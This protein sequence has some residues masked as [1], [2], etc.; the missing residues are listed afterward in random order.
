[1]RATALTTSDESIIL[2]AVPGMLEMPDEYVRVPAGQSRRDEYSFV[3]GSRFR[4]T[5]EF[6]LFNGHY[7]DCSESDQGM[8]VVNLAYLS[9]NPVRVRDQAWRWLIASIVLVGG[10]TLTAVYA[11]LMESIL[12]SVGAMIALYGYLN[13]LRSRII[14]RTRYGGIAVFEIAASVLRRREAERFVSLL[15]E[16][17]EGAAT[18]LPTGEKRLAAEMAE[19]R[20]MLT[21]GWLSKARYDLAKHRIFARYRKNA[22]R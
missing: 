4:R 21:E 3:Q 18:I 8:R 17:I 20:R 5:R 16:R 11:Q 19:H 10:A 13:S 1:M 22:G 12:L 14:F 7:L 2:Q 6:V 15:C 9:C